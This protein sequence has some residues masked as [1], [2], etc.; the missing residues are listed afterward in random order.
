MTVVKDYDI[1]P[2]HIKN[3]SIH[4]MITYIYIYIFI[5]I[6]VAPLPEF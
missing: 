2:G 1:K 3:K 4:D 6:S 5:K